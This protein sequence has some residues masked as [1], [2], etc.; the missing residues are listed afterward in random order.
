MLDDMSTKPERSV[1]AAT[2]GRKGGKAST[3]AQKAARLANLA[4]AEGKRTGRPPGSKNKP[5][6]E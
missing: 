2:L 5:K 4:K 6:P 3:P 1:A